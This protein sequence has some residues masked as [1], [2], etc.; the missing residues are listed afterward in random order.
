[1]KLIFKAKSRDYEIYSSFSN[2]SNNLPSN[3][4]R[5]HKSYI[6]NLDNVTDIQP[7]NNLIIFNDNP[8]IH[9]YIGPKYKKN[10]MEVL[11]NERNFKFYYNKPDDRK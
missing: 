5:C 1:M 6:I 4:I 3:F 8:D 9:C 10:L 2:I 11:Q 7:K